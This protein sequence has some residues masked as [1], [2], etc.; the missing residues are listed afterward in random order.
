MRTHRRNSKNTVLAVAAVAALSMGL[1]AC[2]GTD[3]KGR[4]EGAAAVSSSASASAD[5]AAAPAGQAP[6]TTGTTGATTAGATT[7]S[8]GAATGGKGAAQ[9]AAKP[10][11][12]TSGT[13][14]GKTPSCTFKDMKVTMR[15]ADE[16]PTEHIELTAT[17]TSG[18]AC[19]LDGYPL[20]AFGQIQTAKDIPP[21]AKSKPG[22]PVVLQSGTAAYANVR[23]ANGGAHEA[24]KVVTSFS[25]NFFT[26]SE[27]T[28]GSVDVKAPAGGL[29][30]DEAVAKTGYWTYELR[31]GADEF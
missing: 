4:D 12:A 7:T 9:A 22:A 26:G 18:R 24:N 23:V 31:N 17:N 14:A 28:E 6:G 2:G 20:L 16:V 25:V 10:A 19:R 8:G 13:T 21:V 5:A 3:D 27:P 30:V 11:G 1:T 15:K 29:A